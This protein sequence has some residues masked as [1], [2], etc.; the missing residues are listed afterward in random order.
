MPL[1]V[2]LQQILLHLFNFLLLFFLLSLLLYRPVQ[3]YMEKRQADYAARERQTQERLTAAAQAETEA[4]ERLCAMEKTLQAER[5]RA[6][7]QPTAECEALLRKA[8]EQAD[9]ILRRAQEEAA[10]QAGRTLREGREALTALLLRTA[11][12][13]LAVPDADGGYESFL[14]AAETEHTP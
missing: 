6:L 5:E 10:L 7:Q 8:R 9:A 4:Q 3:K 2:D 1:N 11:E 13:H 12:E 14:L